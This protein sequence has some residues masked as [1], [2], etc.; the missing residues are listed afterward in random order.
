MVAAGIRPDAP[1]EQRVEF[2]LRDR[3]VSHPQ[4]AAALDRLA[5]LLRGA[6]RTCM[7]S[8]L[9]FG[10]PDIGKTTILKK[11]MRGREASFDGETGMGLAEVVAVEAPPE[12]DEARFYAAVLDAVEAP[13]PRGKVGELERA[14][15]GHFR[16]LGTR[17]LVIDE[18]NNLVIGGATAQRRVLAAL[19]R[20]ANQVPLSIAFLGT[21]EALNALTSDPQVEGRS[22]PFQLTRFRNDGAYAQVVRS[23]VAHLPLRGASEVDDAFVGAVHDLT[24][25]SPG[26]TFRLL[27]FAGVNA[28][29]GG[30][31]RLRAASLRS[32]DVARHI[33]TAG[34]M[35]RRARAA[36]G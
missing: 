17:L 16:R 13:I 9:I 32:H 15:H 34:A 22:Q 20:L 24:G 5:E 2:I 23:V 26:K 4:G 10:E 25:G 31:E 18:T 19:R 27:N 29:D 7:P 33:Q 3:W 35:R 36:A 6:R 1:A 11:F 28:I 14:V 8:L 12:A 21:A 30:D